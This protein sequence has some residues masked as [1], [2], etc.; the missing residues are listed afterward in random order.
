MPS[1]A[2]CRVK[3]QPH[4]GPRSLSLCSTQGWVS[5]RAS[6]QSILPCFLMSCLS[7]T[8]LEHGQRWKEA[9]KSCRIGILS[10][11][12]LCITHA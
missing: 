8:G 2:A 11:T 4:E 1:Q 10:H 9:W 5:Q 6:G 3:S 12:A 7:C